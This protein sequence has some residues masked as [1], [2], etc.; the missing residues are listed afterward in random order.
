MLIYRPQLTFLTSWWLKGRFKL[1]QTIFS[2]GPFDGVGGCGELWPDSIISLNFNY[3]N[4][5]SISIK[6]NAK[7]EVTNY[8][9][10]D[11]NDFLTVNY[12]KIYDYQSQVI[13]KTVQSQ[14]NNF[15]KILSYS[16]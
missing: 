6:Y 10:M 11:L 4:Y 9:K 5:N 16:S 14:Y 1:P 2:F 7:T 12:I 8:L 15:Y 13:L 3:I